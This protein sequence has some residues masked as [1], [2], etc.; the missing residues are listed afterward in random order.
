MSAVKLSRLV[1]MSVN[2]LLATKAGFDTRLWPL[3]TSLSEASEN[4]EKSS[5]FWEHLVAPTL[6]MQQRQLYSQQNFL[7][8]LVSKMVLLL[9]F[10]ISLHIERLSLLVV[11]RKVTKSL[12]MVHLV[13]LVLHACRLQNS[14]EWMFMGQQVQKLVYRL[15][16]TIIA[17]RSTTEKKVIL[18]NSRKIRTVFIG[19]SNSDLW[20]VPGR[21]S[22]GVKNL[23][24][25][26]LSLIL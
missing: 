9:V 20:L 5:P 24:K 16:K 15:S 8:V 22:L 7:P 26:N 1:L 25:T 6:S 14:W 3:M 4:L 13:V 23:L 17:I 18:T 21:D 10:H 19:H 11:E 12:S 2:F